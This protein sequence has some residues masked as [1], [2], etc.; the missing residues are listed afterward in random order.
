M[1]YVKRMNEAEIPARVL[2]YKPEGKRGVGR[3]KL[4]R[5]DDVREDLR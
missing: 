3:Q 1:G 4:Q 2:D 5:L